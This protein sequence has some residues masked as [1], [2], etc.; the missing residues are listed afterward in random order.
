V[1]VSE[2]FER[3]I[4][5]NLEK[6]GYMRGW[7]ISSVM[8]DGAQEYFCSELSD[9]LNDGGHGDQRSIQQAANAMTQ[10][11]VKLLSMN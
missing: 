9:E 6:I 5:T 2:E 3:T 1:T 10:N 11:C 7:N 4:T 8:S